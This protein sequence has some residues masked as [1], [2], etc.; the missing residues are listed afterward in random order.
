MISAASSPT[1]PCGLRLIMAILYWTRPKDP[2]LFVGAAS[3]T[4]ASTT[5][6]A[7]GRSATS[8][9]DL[10][11]VTLVRMFSEEAMQQI[12]ESSSNINIRGVHFKG[13]RDRRQS[14]R[15][16]IEFLFLRSYKFLYPSKSSFAGN[17]S[18]DARLS[19]RFAIDVPALDP[20]FNCGTN[21]LDV[22]V[23]D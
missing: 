2:P 10:S 11:N 4:P 15:T 7:L 17:R 13:Q 1:A 9:E 3:T 5:S 20:T 21:Y 8:L 18:V 22:L 23:F 19:A 12:M 16:N 6:T 14:A